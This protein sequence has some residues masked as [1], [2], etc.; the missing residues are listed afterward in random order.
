[1]AV[2]ILN[3][4]YTTPFKP[5]STTNFFLGNVGDWQWLQMVCEF[6]VE[7]DFQIS[8]TMTIADPN[9]LILSQGTWES[10]GFAIGM[11][12]NFDF[13]VLDLDTGSST[14]NRITFD[15]GNVYGNTLEAVDVG[16][17]TPKTT[18][19]YQYGQIAPIRNADVE[20]KD[21]LVF[22][23]VRPQGIEL[24]YGH[25]TN[26]AAP[27]GNLA[28]P[29]DGT[30][31]RF[32]A[33]NTDT[34]P[35]LAPFDF[36]HFLSFQ[37][38]MSVE[39]ASLYYLGSAGHKYNYVIDV[40]Y[41]LSPFFEDINDLKNLVTPSFLLGAESITDNFEIIGTPVYNNPNVTI[42]NDPK[43]TQKKGNVGWF[44]ENFN[45]LPN[46]FTFTPVV[47]KNLAGTT[48]ASLDHVNPVTI[49]TT[50]SG[51]Q[52][53]S[54]ATRF[55]YGFIWT[56]IDEDLYQ[57]E[58]E[59]FHELLKVSTGGQAATMGDVF[60]LSPLV[61]SPFP[62]LRKGYSIDTAT[63][64]ASDISFVQN[65]LSV[66]VTM[67]FRPSLDF[68]NYMNTL[69]E[70][71]RQYSLW[72]SVGDSA[73]ATNQSDRVSLLIEKNNT[74]T[75]FIEPIGEY[76][77]MEIGFLNHPQLSTE[78]PSTCGNSIF[79]EDDLLAKISFQVDTATGPTIPIPTAINY[80]FMVEDINTGA[81]YVLENTPI[82][83]T[84]YP[85]PTQYNYDASRGFKLGVNNSKNFIKVDY[86]PANNTGSLL[87]VLGFYGFKIRWEDWIARFPV[88]PAA[89]YDNTQLNNGKNNDWFHYFNTS[90]W[91]FLFFVNTSAI[92]NGSNVVYQNTQELIIKDYDSNPII[93][94]E[95]KYY[96]N[97]NGVKG[98][99]LI[100][101]TDPLTGDPLG[102]IIR[103]EKVFLDIEYTRSVGT[104][105]DVL[106]SYA[107]N[108]IE[109][110][111]GAGFKEFRQ[112]SSIFVPEFTNPLEGVTGTTLSTLTLVSPTVLRVE[113]M[114][115]SNKL[116]NAPRYKVSG[117]LGCK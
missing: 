109:V 7:V 68:S 85:D 38:G 84:Q 94:T 43:I 71:E 105:V 27:S 75:T 57:E 66:D 30:L 92:L 78:T 32:K 53:L 10:F 20:I 77:G 44:N 56:S 47:Y 74:M 24:T 60:P 49:T 18:W 51:I 15:I 73:P 6:A 28:S 33:E 80:G 17:S 108:C 48:V 23:D 111:K 12:V 102:V 16:T 69:S 25:P 36:T 11:T 91:R 112:L 72:I 76:D 98:P 89:F 115:D 46:P 19:G 59:P 39:K 1:M 101:G 87:G 2:K 103:G 86:D 54:T 3:K 107:L 9:K 22:A 88:A 90:G 45:Q 83:L 99:Q 97:N 4:Q 37:S 67:T 40:V 116:I 64:D 35:I 29:L 100:G 63:M 95:L 31:T 110:D 117:R 62:A 79:V 42:K 93:S 14:F 113:C 81:T 61:S 41:M 106:S 13:Y 50:I 104:W 65:G 55:Q 96:Q 52:N 58:I 70:N 34:M 21:V 114:I 8:N 5:A 82:D 26:T